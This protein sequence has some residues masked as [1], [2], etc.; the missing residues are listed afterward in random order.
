MRA[1]RGG[2]IP[3]AVNRD[4][5]KSFDAESYRMLPPAELQAVYKEIPS[6]SRIIT[7]CQTGQRAAYTSLVLRALGYKDV[8]IYMTVGGYTVAI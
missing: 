7:H 8:A 3:Q 6:G 2:H 1:L 4:Y 5:A